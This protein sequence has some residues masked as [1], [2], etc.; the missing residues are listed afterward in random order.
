[1]VINLGD[2]P[3]GAI[4]DFKWNTN[5]VAGES[6]TRAT[7]GS[8]RIYKGNSAVER[9][10]A[11]GITDTEDFDALTG[12]HHLRIDLSDNT[13]AGFYAAGNEYQVVL[14]GAVI[15][16]KTINAVIAIFSIERANGILA[17][18]KDATNG[19]TAIKNAVNT[20]DDFVDTEV[21][22]IKAATDQ[23]AFTAGNVHSRVVT[24]ATGAITADA[25]AVDF[26]AEVAD[27]VWDEPLAGH[28][29]AG[30]AGKAMQIARAQGAGKWAIV[31][32]VLTV[33]DL[34]AVTVVATLTLTPAGGPYTARAP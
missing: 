26:G 14:V 4:L 9:T 20:V 5:A 29:T 1:M 19:L 7:N 24:M 10:S 30:T 23:L 28:L 21:A 31:G 17:L 15:D 33:Y 27:A 32:D 3:A 18:I 22:A 12:L 8:I 16:G 6:I 34:D 13:D 11:A 2:Y 25:A